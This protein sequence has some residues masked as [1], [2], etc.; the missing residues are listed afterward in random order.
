[1]HARSVHQE[2]TDQKTRRSRAFLPHT[3]PRS[4]PIFLTAPLSDNAVALHL[5]PCEKLWRY[6]KLPSNFPRSER[7]GNPAIDVFYVDELRAKGLGLALQIRQHP[8]AILLF[9]RLLARVHV[10]RPRPHHALD[11][12][13][14]LMR[15]R[16]HRFWCPE[17]GPHPTLI[18]PQGTVTVGDAWGRQPQG[19]RRPIGRW[20]APH[21]VTFAP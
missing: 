12:P 20:F 9:I 15:G 11:E 5:G 14:Q 2:P 16:R 7:R 10:G 8:I 6:R 3:L 21:P 17:P 4:P 19:R 13:G 18:G 1:M